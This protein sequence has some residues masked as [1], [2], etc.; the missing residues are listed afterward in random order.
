M[1][2]ADELKM[3]IFQAWSETFLEDGDRHVTCRVP[4][5]AWT[6]IHDANPEAK[7]LFAK[8]SAG[9]ST[10]FCALGSPVRPTD[11]SDAPLYLPEWILDRL[12]ICG[13]GETVSVEWLPEEAF[14]EATRIILRPHDS[15]FYHADA[16]EELERMLTQIG[17][18][19][20]GITIKL[21]MSELGGYEI[22]FD[23]ITVEPARLVLM[24]GDEVAMEFEEALDAPT[25]TQPLDAPAALR[26]PTPIP[27][28]VAPIMG[29]MVPTAPVM[30][31]AGVKIFTGEG[32]T[33]GG[34][35]RRMA[36]GR[37]WNPYRA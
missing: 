35:V 21:P 34:Q 8:I 26:P 29:P 13:E 37:P 30:V 27:E 6:R 10:A 7:R 1:V 3:S 31:D 19:E 28:E 24:Q 4:E 25:T 2:A 16:K 12:P 22:E 23:V 18:L 11:M 20:Q 14:P 36:D 5:R 15:A 9:G 17:I 33:L 32:R